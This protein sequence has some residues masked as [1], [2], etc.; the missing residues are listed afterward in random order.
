[1]A[2]A[3]YLTVPEV[4][5]TPGKLML[6]GE[7]AVLRPH[8][9][10]LA[11][12]VGEVVRAVWG[13][14][15][16]GVTLHAFG[17]KLPL[18]TTGLPGYAAQAIAW[19]EARGVGMPNAHLTLH[20]A[21]AVGAAKVG[22]GTSAA[23][24]VATLR[25]LLEAR[26][27]L[28]SA[29][30]VSAAA[31]EIHG[32]GQ[33]AGSGYD[34]TAIAH[35]GVTAYSRTPDTATPLTWPTG[36][37]GAALFSGQP[38]ATGPALQKA[39]LTSAH[40]DAIGQAARQ[41][42]DAWTCEPGDILEALATCDAAYLAAASVDPSLVPPAV[43]QTRQAIADGGCVARGSGAGGGDCVL[44]FTDDPQRIAW[45]CTHWTNAGHVVVARLPA[46]I[47]PRHT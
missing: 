3:W 19:L 46:D 14:G 12:A 28:W 16:T 33:G 38:A 1:M 45:L 8:G 13:P 5:V 27:L 32:T 6:A 44:A 9:V 11:V 18:S 43:A 29:A 10:C 30:E 20:V 15:Q 41:L 24:T 39:P 47:A 21:G 4:R 17:Q 35:G 31:R 25:A 36:L 34:V 22:L 2:P 42:V 26:G 37:Y 23:V 7:Y 40:L